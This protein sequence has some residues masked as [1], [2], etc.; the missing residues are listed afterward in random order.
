MSKPTTFTACLAALTLDAFP[1]LGLDYSNAVPCGECDRCKARAAAK[2]RRLCPVDGCP[3]C[4][5]DGG[6]S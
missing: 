6:C 4:P 5:F 2:A 3:P 1:T